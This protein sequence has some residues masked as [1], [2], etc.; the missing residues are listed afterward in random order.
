MGASRV[1]LVQA[2]HRRSTVVAV[3]ELVMQ[4]RM[5]CEGE[6]PGDATEEEILALV[7]SQRWASGLTVP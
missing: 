5:P 6:L 3:V 7:R 2:I 4:L 1:R